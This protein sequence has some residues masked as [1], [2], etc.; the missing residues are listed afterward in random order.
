MAEQNS[1]DVVSKV[2]MQEVKNAVDQALKEIHQRFDFKGTK[3]EL[4][5]KEKDNELV[6]LSDDEYKLKS[7][8]D[9]VKA[10]LVKRN[11]SVKAFAFG[12]I[13]PALGGT[14]RQIAKI[15]NGLT[16]EKAKEITK[17]IKEAK[18]KAQAQIQADQVRVQ[19]KSRDELQAVIAFLKGKD[20]GV[21]LQFINY[22]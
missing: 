16:T 9:I 19:G 8:V 13:E 22:R 12:A 5:L 7:V 17:E 11:V 6:V 21:D 20:F 2:D 18:F 4:T 3:T 1:F 10:K 15:Q 14:V